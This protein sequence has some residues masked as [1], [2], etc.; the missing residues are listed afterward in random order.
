MTIYNYYDEC[1]CGHLVIWHS[2][3][4]DSPKDKMKCVGASHTG[5]TETGSRPKQPECT[6]KEFR[7]KKPRAERLAKQMG[8]GEW[9]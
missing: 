9:V 8:T 5:P 6:C 3:P 1:K 2:R 4:A 7:L